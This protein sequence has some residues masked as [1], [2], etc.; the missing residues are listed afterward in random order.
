VWRDRGEGRPHAAGNGSG[1]ARHRETEKHYNAPVF[2][3]GPRQT[4]QRGTNENTNGLLRFFLSKRTDFGKAMDGA[5][6]DRRAGFALCG[7]ERAA[8]MRRGVG[9][10]W[11]WAGR[12]GIEERDSRCV[13]GR[14][15][16]PCGGTWVVLGYGRVVAVWESGIRAVWCGEGSPHAAGRGLCLATGGALRDRRAGFALRGRDRAAPMRRNGGCAW[17]RVGRCGIGE[18]DLCCV[19]GRGQPPC[20]GTG[21]VLGYERA[22]VV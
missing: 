1:F 12:C 7:R 5:L 2:F 9:C 10:A 19:V 13:V 4:W 21:V 17:L 20:G 11:L 6:R 18:R 14:G 16:P 22:A 3:D 8:P 15:Q